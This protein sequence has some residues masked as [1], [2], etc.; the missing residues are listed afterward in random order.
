MEPDNITAIENGSFK[1]LKNLHRLFLDLNELTFINK[2]MLEGL[3]NLEELSFWENKISSIEVDS[4]SE[5][6]TLTSLDLS[7]TRYLNKSVQYFDISIY[8]SINRLN[9]KPG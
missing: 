5:L 9:L 3:Q 8:N 1:G 7:C 2:A 4:F 6:F